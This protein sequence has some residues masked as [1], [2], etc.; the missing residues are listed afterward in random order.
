MQRFLSSFFPAQGA[1][2]Y[3]GSGN[4]VEPSL[5]RSAVLEVVG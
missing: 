2:T 5:P 1:T 3:G 4:L